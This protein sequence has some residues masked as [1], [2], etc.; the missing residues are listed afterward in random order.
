MV[1]VRTKEQITET[2]VREDILNL[3]RPRWCT[4]HT[5][6]QKA[7]TQ[8]NVVGFFSWLHVSAHLRDIVLDMK[9]DNN[10]IITDT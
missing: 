10:K 1:R 3:T 2:F 4:N 5:Q 9:A 8:H 7:N 6:V